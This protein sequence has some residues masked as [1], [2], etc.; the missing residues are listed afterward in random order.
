LPKI[1]T[2]RE[3]TVAYDTRC[4]PGTHQI[5]TTVS[6][7]IAAAIAGSIRQI[8]TRRLGNEMIFSPIPASPR[9]CSKRASTFAAGSALAS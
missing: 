3:S 1:S 9:P 5:A 6:K 2:I 8:V 4:R 7:T